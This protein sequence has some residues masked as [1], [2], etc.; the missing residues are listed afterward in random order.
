[1][2]QTG[3]KKKKGGTL[4]TAKGAEK[5]GGKSKDRPRL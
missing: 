1:M 5:Q 3:G 4:K 2:T